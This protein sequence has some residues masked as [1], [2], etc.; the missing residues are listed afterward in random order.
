MSETPSNM[1]LKDG[2]TVPE[3]PESPVSDGE[4]ESVCEIVEPEAVG[5]LAH[6]LVRE[7]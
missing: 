1:T 4:A 5:D 7:S 6:W 2:L 3:S